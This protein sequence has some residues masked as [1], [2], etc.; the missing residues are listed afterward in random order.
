MLA[1]QAVGDRVG[2]QVGRLVQGAQPHGRL[3]G[4]AEDRAQLVAARHVDQAV[5]RRVARHAALEP[6]ASADH[7][8]EQPDLDEPG[9]LLGVAPAFGLERRDDAE[10]A[11]LAA[12]QADH[13]ADL[14]MGGAGRVEH[15]P[16]HR[17][18][19]RDHVAEQRVGRRARGR[20]GGCRLLV[21]EAALGLCR[22][23]RRATVAARPRRLLVLVGA[24][25]N[26]HRAVLGCSGF[27][28]PGPGLP[29]LPGLRGLGLGLS[30]LGLEVRLSGRR[31]QGFAERLPHGKGECRILAA[32]RVLV[33]GRCP[34]QQGPSR[35]PA[36]PQA[37]QR[38]RHP[39]SRLPCRVRGSGC[40]AEGRIGVR[41]AGLAEAPAVLALLA[42][43]LA[44]RRPASLV[45][46][47]AAWCGIC[48]RCRSRR[49]LPPDEPV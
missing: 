32:R 23:R 8:A 3:V 26:G 13:R 40:G 17:A 14:G 7:L 49:R 38:R 42:Q 19:D 29:W 27:C 35:R 48:G 10:A 15:R 30:G 34:A 6:V 33:G 9:R 24:A 28:L 31:G 1:E 41:I 36:P 43:T 47:P 39:T 45:A 4:P 21:A 44:H 11:H 12:L 46:T 5:E 22:R 20:K 2:R 25:G 16:D 37:W 18:R